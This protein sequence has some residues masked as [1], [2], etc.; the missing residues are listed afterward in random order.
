M[1]KNQPSD[2]CRKVIYTLYSIKTRNTERKSIKNILKPINTVIKE[3]SLG[4]A[5]HIRK[6][7]GAI[8]MYLFHLSRSKTFCKCLS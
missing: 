3:K 7:K 6:G 2:F 4:K 1:L 5:K 8:D